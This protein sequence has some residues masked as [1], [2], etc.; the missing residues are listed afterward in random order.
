MRRE[1]RVSAE[2]FLG[3]MVERDVDPT[4]STSPPF[5]KFPLP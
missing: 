1:D 3:R 5:R 2:D 4:E